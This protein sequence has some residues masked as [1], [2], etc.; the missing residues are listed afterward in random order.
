MCCECDF[1]EDSGG[2][3]ERGVHA[4]LS[5]TFPFLEQWDMGYL[6]FALT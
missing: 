4:I 5:L 2:N 3:Q 6:C 1:S